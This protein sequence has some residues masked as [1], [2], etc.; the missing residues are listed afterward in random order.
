MKG[1]ILFDLV[2]I[3]HGVDEEGSEEADHTERNQE[4][5]GSEICVTSHGETPE[6]RKNYFIIEYLWK[7][8]PMLVTTI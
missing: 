5:V 2:I 4:S 6:W 1:C 7:R 8:K 3:R